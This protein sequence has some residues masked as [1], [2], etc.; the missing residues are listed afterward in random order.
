LYPLKKYAENGTELPSIRKKELR[1]RAGFGLV[2]L[3]KAAVQSSLG[4]LV[5][6]NAA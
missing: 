2:A 3:I 4:L 6:F 1:E 5:S